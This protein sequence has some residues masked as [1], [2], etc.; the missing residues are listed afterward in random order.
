M[1]Q[2]GVFCIAVPTDITDVEKRAFYE[3]AN[4]AKI[5]AKRITIVEKPVADGVGIGIDVD[6][7][8]GYMVVNFGAD[9]T[10]ISVLSL[11]GIVISKLVQVGGNRLDENIVSLVKKKYNLIIGLKTAENLK[12]GLGNASEKEDAGMK[13]FGRDLVSGLP[14]ER[15]ISAETVYEATHDILQNITSSIKMILERTPPELAADIIG[16]GIYITGGSAHLKNFGVLVQRETDLSV[17]IPPFPAECVVRG[18]A[19]ILTDRSYAN[20]SYVPREKIIY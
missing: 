9:T 12:K 15:E 10:E 11:G 4:N 14:M 16:S 13:V 8:K 17:N 7:P 3:L 5:K 6:S 2:Q 20:L 18:T 1:L 19:K